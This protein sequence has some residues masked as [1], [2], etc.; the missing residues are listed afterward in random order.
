MS[1]AK[2]RPILFSVP[3]VR[4]I[5][6]GRKTMTRRVVNPQAYSYANDALGQPCIY[7]RDQSG[8]ADPVPIYCPYGVPGDRL[9]VREAFRLP[10]NYDDATPEEIEAQ[11]SRTSVRY[12]ADGDIDL[13]GK[14]RPSI[15][16]RR[17]WSRILLD[18]VSVRVERL[19]DIHE[20]DAMAEG[21]S[22]T[23]GFFGIQNDV[24]KYMFATTAFKA[25][26][27]SINAKRGYGWDANPWT[28]VV[29][30]KLVKP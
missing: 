11:V 19:Q 6:E 26:W 30:F 12:L 17:C 18:V 5:L 13:S 23:G 29:E 2:E 25:L 4:A 3:M 16:M 1:T 27:D 14:N 28:W 10:S 9:W 20:H 15:F 8:Y 22:V 21:I 24:T 7:P